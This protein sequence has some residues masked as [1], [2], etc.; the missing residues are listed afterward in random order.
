MFQ[1]DNIIVLLP[2]LLLNF[3]FWSGRSSQSNSK[4]KAL[5]SS[6]IICLIIKRLGPGTAEG[7]LPIH[8]FIIG[9]ELPLMQKGRHSHWA[10]VLL[11]TGMLGY[12]W[13]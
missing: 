13:L 5:S 7:T 6:L 11:V 1:S 10:M 9:I 2:T 3:P 4:A 8:T 12:V